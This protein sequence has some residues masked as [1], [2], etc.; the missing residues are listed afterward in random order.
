MIRTNRILFAC[1]VAC[2]AA[3]PTLAQDDEA[4]KLRSRLKTIATVEKKLMIPMRDGVRLA[5]DVYLPAEGEGPFPTIFWRTPYNFNTL[6]SRRARLAMGAIEKG[7]AFVIQNERGKF[8]SEGE[9]EI[10]GFPRTDG[11]DALDWIAAQPWSNGRVGTIGCSSSAEWQL[12][13]AAMDHPAHA[14]MV[15]MASGAG[16]GRVGRFHEQGNWYRGGVYQMLFGTWLYGVQNT[17]R[18]RLPE[19]L[20]RE[21]VIR[22]SRYFDL[23]P[24]MPDID[25]EKHIEH[26]PLVTMMEEAQGP[27]GIY[28]EFVRRLP[29]DPAWYDGGLYHDDE[30]WGVPALWFNS[31]YDV[32]IGPN[33]ELFNHA[34]D[35]GVDQEARD[36]QYAVIAPTPHCRFWTEDEETVVGER[37]MGDVRFDTDGLVARWFDYWLKGEENGVLE[38]TPRVQYYTMGENVWQSADTWP[39]AGIEVTPWYLGSDGGA[40]SLFGD[41]RLSLEAGPGAASDSFVYDPTVPVPSLGGGVCCTGGAVA[42]GSFDQRGIEA[43]HDVLVYTSD[44]LDEAIEV[45]GSVEVTLWVG[46][47]ARDTDFTVKLVDVHPDGTAYNIDETIQRARFR[48]GYE[49]EVFMEPGEVYRLEVSPMTTSATIGAGHRL[50]VEI[51][52]SNF[53]RF[54]RNLNTGGNNAEEAEGVPARNVVYHSAEYPSQV[55]LPIV[56][57]D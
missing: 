10:L 19:G 16:I 35:K 23:A 40:N 15:P 38:N 51:S 45:T 8:F 18:P 46:S 27:K 21:D 22:L 30:P 41:G 32:S 37:N 55:R 33:M 20:S 26:L 49:R 7:Y 17:Q 29:D 43:R 50:R 42:P 56:Q 28:A 1:A 25:W 24:D 52:S 31:W 54:A 44:P 48:E 5:T 47:D 57:D 36:G 34:R 12:A 6:S 4:E 53:P 11:W 13:L 3:W 9:W 14:A 2:V 39:P